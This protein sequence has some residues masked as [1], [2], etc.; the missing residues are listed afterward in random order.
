MGTSKT[1]IIGIIIVVLSIVIGLTINLSRPT[2]EEIETL[3]KAYTEKLN[4]TKCG[5]KEH[6]NLQTK[7]YEY[8][9]QYT[10]RGCKPN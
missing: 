9:K 10:E 1:C 8:E 2:C 5:T 6:Y 7:I 3:I 4:K